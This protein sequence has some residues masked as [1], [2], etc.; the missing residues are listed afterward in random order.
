MAENQTAICCFIFSKTGWKTFAINGAMVVMVQY[1]MVK[2]I[3][4]T[5]IY[6]QLGYG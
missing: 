1:C 3:H 4:I 5:I 6:I 2:Y